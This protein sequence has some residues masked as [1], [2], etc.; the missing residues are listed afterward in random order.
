MNHTYNINFIE[1]SYNY[2]MDFIKQSIIC[3][4]PTIKTLEQVLKYVH[5]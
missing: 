2:D 1:F 4:E 5:S 3:S